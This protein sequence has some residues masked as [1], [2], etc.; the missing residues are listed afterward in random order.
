MTCNWNVGKEFYPVPKTCGQLQADIFSSS[1]RILNSPPGFSIF[2]YIL[3]KT[4]TRKKNKTASADLF[5]Q[6]WHVWAVLPSLSKCRLFF[7]LWFSDWTS[8]TLTLWPPLM[9]TLWSDGPQHAMYH[10]QSGSVESGLALKKQSVARTS[11][12]WTVNKWNLAVV[13]PG[14][15][16]T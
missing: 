2:Q 7:P 10:L 13:R 14:T 15:K 9:V 16:K 4:M 6:K 3:Q 8:T 12:S 5:H 1:I 11:G